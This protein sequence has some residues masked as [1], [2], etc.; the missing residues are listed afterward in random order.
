MKLAELLAIASYKAEE[1][2][3]DT[4]QRPMDE[5]AALAGF[6]QNPFR[7]EAPGWQSQ[8]EVGFLWAWQRIVLAPVG[9]ALSAHGLTMCSGGRCRDRQVW[10]K[11][12]K[13]YTSA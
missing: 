4:E 1:I 13:R 9:R 6:K 12:T 10:M 5:E 8:V 3:A 7:W 11:R 2:R